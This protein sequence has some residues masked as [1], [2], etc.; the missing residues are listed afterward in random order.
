[1]FNSIINVSGNLTMCICILL[2]ATPLAVKFGKKTVAVVGFGLSTVTSLLFYVMDPTNC[3]GML[4]TQVVCSIV[5]A[6]TIPLVWAMF[7][8]VADYSE[9]QTGRRF[10]GMVFATFGFALKAGLA[11]GSSWFLWIMT[12]MFDY[13]TKAPATEN[14]VEGYLFCSSIAVSV[15]FGICTVLLAVYQ[16]GKDETIKLAKDLEAQRAG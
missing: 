5:Y 1:V 6:P 14:A 7:A 2:F 9:W 13:D 4:I 12:G 8:D 10:T 3:I 11:F 16:L 15:M